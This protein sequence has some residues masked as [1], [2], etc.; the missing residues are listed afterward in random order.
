MIDTYE[1]V[2]VCDLTSG[3]A[4]WGEL[5]DLTAD[6][7]AKG[8]PSARVLIAL[9]LGDL[10]RWRE[11]FARVREAARLQE[12]TQAGHR[13]SRSRATRRSPR[14]LAKN[15]KK[16]RRERRARFAYAS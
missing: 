7:P 14:L 4:V 13:R 12:D 5:V 6:V 10:R 3:K 8:Y 2:T 15:S 16:P 9:M 1:I 11:K